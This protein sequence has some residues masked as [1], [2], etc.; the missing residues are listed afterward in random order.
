M[1]KVSFKSTV[2]KAVVLGALIAPT[3]LPLAAQAEGNVAV[4]AVSPIEG[5]TQVSTYEELKATLA[6]VSVSVI[7]VT[8]DITFSRS[9]T[10]VPSRDVKVY[11]AEGAKIDLGK[12]HIS[13]KTSSKEKATFTLENLNVVGS[14]SLGTFL[15]ASNG[16][17]F[18]SKDNTFDGETLV[19]LNNGTL[20]FEGT[21]TI[22]TE[23]EIGWVAHVVFKD[24][25]VLNGV[26]A[27][28]GHDRSA[29]K[30]KGTYENGWQGTATVE[31]G[32]EVN[33]KVK[34]KARSAFNG[35]INQINL[36]NDSILRIE[37]EGT[38]LA[39]DKSLQH[40][41]APALNVGENAEFEIHSNGSD[42]GTKPA[43]NLEQPGSQVNA[44]EGS[45][46]YITGEGSEGVIFSST[47]SSINVDGA[48][49]FELGNKTIGAPIFNTKKGTG[50]ITLDFKNEKGVKGFSDYNTLYKDWILTDATVSVVNGA[51]TSVSS[52]NDE[53]NKEFQVQNFGKI[54][55][56]ASRT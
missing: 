6:D 1:K 51:T 11:S 35:K 21:N 17:D 30:F 43:L 48:R 53:F 34:N 41:T 40:K 55:L 56:W 3:V 15:K 27:N 49:T 13:A 31:T 54:T 24:A 16:W 14:R 36:Q 38:G 25:S 5:A 44:A 22:D 32:A 10:G 33:L 28:S 20:S 26:A 19:Q 4:T 8:E 39:F 46:V 37:T 29:F 45:Y 23:D 47:N 12:Y 9:I 50:N 2:T 42:K 18:V 7:E 52:E